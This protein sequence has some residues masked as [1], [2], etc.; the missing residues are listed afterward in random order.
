[1]GWDGEGELNPDVAILVAKEF[2][3]VVRDSI[4]GAN[5]RKDSKNNNYKIESRAIDELLP[6]YVKA[7]LKK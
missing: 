4:E 3:Q 5:S 1:V 6:A 7:K 2:S